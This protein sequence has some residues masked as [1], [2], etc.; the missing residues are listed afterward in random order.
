MTDEL[1]KRKPSEER[2]HRE[3]ASAGLG[4]LL[5]NMHASCTRY[6]WE[7]SQSARATAICMPHRRVTHGAAGR[8][9]TPRLTGTDL[10]NK[11]LW[12]VADRDD[13]LHTVQ[14]VPFF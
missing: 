11:G 3:D 9:N 2:V 10:K 14:V 12:E 7:G 5:S 4:I 6:Q 13:A 8:H 1:S